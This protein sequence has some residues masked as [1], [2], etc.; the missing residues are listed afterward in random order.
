MNSS[1]ILSNSPIV[2]R[3]EE[4]R[5][6]EKNAACEVV[7]PGRYFAKDTILEIYDAL[8]EFMKSGKPDQTRPTPP[9]ADP[10]CCHPAKQATLPVMGDPARGPES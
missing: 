7:K 6:E 1:V 9:P 10:R 3:N 8:A 4:A 2:K 5:T